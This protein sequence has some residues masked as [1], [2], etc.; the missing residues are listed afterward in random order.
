MGHALGRVGDPRVVDDLRNHDDPTAWCEIAAGSYPVGGGQARSDIKPL[1]KQ[2][3]RIAQPFRI[4]RYPVTNSQFGVFVRDGGYENAEW[5][6]DEGWKWRERNS[7]VRPL[8]W[9]DAK[10]NGANQPVVGVCFWE[11][12]AFCPWAGGR[13]PDEREWEVA[14]RGSNEYEYP[15]GSEWKE[16]VCNTLELRLGRTTPVGLFPTSRSQP[17]QLDDAAGNV[18]EWCTNEVKSDV[19]G[20]C[21]V[22]RGGSWYGYRDVARCGFRNW[23]LPVSRSINL[24]FRLCVFVSPGLASR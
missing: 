10:W 13:L 17:A 18:W 7:V 22:V 6:S 3:F 23:W 16:N 12:D 14:V 19:L 15:W 4:T 2:R 11:A 20:V 8:Y 9:N 21:R 5:W 1:K 24:G